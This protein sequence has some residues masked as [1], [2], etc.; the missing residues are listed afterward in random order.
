MQTLQTQLTRFAVYAPS[1]YRPAAFLVAPVLEQGVVTGAL[2]LQLDVNRLESVTADR[3]G[4]G[5][6][7]ETVLAQKQGDE[8]FYTAPLRHVRS[9]AYHH[10]VPLLDPDLPI[11]KALQGDHG[12][13]ITRDYAGRE[14]VAAWR[15]LP[16]LNWGMA[17]KIDADEA[18][19]PAA[20]MRGITYSALASILLVSGLVAFFLGRGCPA[21]RGARGGRP[22]A[23][24]DL[25]SVPRRP[26]SS[27]WAG[28]PWLSSHAEGAG[29]IAEN[30]EAQVETRS[31]GCAQ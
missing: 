9:A 17:V 16:A 3:T 12:R 14:V 13:G 20:R 2:A 1:G 21:R 24:G 8:A 26:T 15:Y 31:R 5:H 25:T 28:C 29:G 4:L 18:L 19:A 7:G 27:N 10:R 6:S 23:A 30:L 11:R 22:V